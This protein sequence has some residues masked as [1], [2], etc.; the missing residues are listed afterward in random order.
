[1]TIERLAE[2]GRAVEDEITG[3]LLWRGQTTRAGFV[4]DR[5]AYVIAFE[6][7]NGPVPDGR[8]VRHRCDQPG[9]FAPAHLYAGTPATNVRDAWSRGRSRG[10]VSYSREERKARGVGWP[11]SARQT[12]AA[13]RAGRLG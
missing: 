1:M 11:D 5:R 9:C 3:C 8:I 10:F 2:I 4:A 7:G 6:I 13:N 12:A